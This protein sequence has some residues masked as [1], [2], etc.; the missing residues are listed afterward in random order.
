MNP[1]SVLVTEPVR[2]APRLARAGAVGVNLLPGFAPVFPLIG[3]AVTDNLRGMGAIGVLLYAGVFSGACTL[4]VIIVNAV[5]LIK[6]RQTLGLAYFGLAIEGAR[7]VRLLLAE[8]TL[9]FLPVTIAFLISCAVSGEEDQQRAFVGV[10]LALYAANWLCGLGPT[11][12][13]LG[14]RLGGGRVVVRSVYE[15]FAQPRLRWSDLVLIALPG[16]TIFFTLSEPLVSLPGV[17]AS[18]V[19]AALVLFKRLR[20]HDA[21]S[22]LA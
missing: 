2:S 1:E 16:W 3:L 20:R 6:R 8:G 5:L 21:H 15:P 11:R 9:L 19:V 12:R 13:T 17:L 22:P 14:D 7:S 10:L 4:L 18:G